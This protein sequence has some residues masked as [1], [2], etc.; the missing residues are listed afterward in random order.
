MSSGAAPVSSAMSAARDRVW[1]EM[2]SRSRVCSAGLAPMMR[3]D[4]ATTCRASAA[5]SRGDRSIRKRPNAAS[6]DSS[7]LRSRIAVRRAAS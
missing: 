3:A 1:L 5:A 7:G 4:A 6:T 2:I